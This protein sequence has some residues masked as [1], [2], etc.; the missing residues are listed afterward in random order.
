MDFDQLNTFIEVARLNSFS[1]AALKCYRTQPAVSAQIRL[2]EDEVGARLFDRG[3]GRVTLTAAGKVFLQ[4]AEKL[5]LMRKEAIQSVADMEHTPRGELVI[6]ANE[7]SCLHVLPEVFAEFKREHPAVQVRIRRGEHIDILESVLEN[8]VDFGVVSLPVDDDR[9]KIVPLHRDEI[10]AL[11]AP[12]HPLA[13]RAARRPST[14]GPRPIEVDVEQLVQYPLLLPKSGNTREALD[15]LLQPCAGRV[16]ISMELDSTELLKGFA[17]AGL[18]IGF[19]GRTMAQAEVRSGELVLLS[20]NGVK[21][22]RDL[23][24]IFR[25]DRALGRAALA[26]ID[27]AVHRRSPAAEKPTTTRTTTASGQ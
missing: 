6:S 19:A 25:R 26:F 7:G 8:R 20:I 24:L 18:G 27:L 13:Q 10:H 16:N 4:Y 14:N 9:L 21:I 12:S 2:L 5:T 23:A 17:A 1:R 22:Y 11:V 3:G 15:E